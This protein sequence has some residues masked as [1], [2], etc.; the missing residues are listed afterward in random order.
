M[1][2]VG[3]V[4]HARVDTRLLVAVG[5]LIGGV[6][7]LWM[8]DFYLGVSFKHLVLLRMLQSASLAF[9]FVPINT[10]A[11][12]GVPPQKTNN[13]S[14]LINL[15]H[16][17]G[18]SIGISLMLTLLTRREQFHQSRIVEQLQ[19]LNTAYPGFAHQ[20]GN[21]LGSA[22]DAPTTLAAIYSQAVSRRRSCRTWTT[23]R[24][25]ASY[26]SGCCRS[27]CWSKPGRAAGRRP[28]LTEPGRGLLLPRP[29]A[30]LS[31]KH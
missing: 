9:L 28:R 25:W 2:Q 26:S 29:A 23:S 31:Q 5:L 15:A 10:P 24:F 6:S 4:F 17:L 27:C 7:L 22:P 1:Y 3:F 18:G 30:I 14:A 13:A 20:L 21:A 11:F 19:P 8:T 12:R 16:N